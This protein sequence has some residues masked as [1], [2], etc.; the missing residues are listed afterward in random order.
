MMTFA[1]QGRLKVLCCGCA[2]PKGFDRYEHFTM[3]PCRCWNK[4]F[5]QW[6]RSG[7]QRRGWLCGAR[8]SAPPQCAGPA[9][10]SSQEDV[11]R[12]ATCMIQAKRVAVGVLSLILLD[13]QASFLI[14]LTMS[15]EL[16]CICCTGKGP[17]VGRFYLPDLGGAAATALLQGLLAEPCTCMPSDISCSGQG[18][19]LQLRDMKGARESHFHSGSHLMLRWCISCAEHPASNVAC[20]VLV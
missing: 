3:P 16:S 4:G 6:R 20:L 8:Q 5:L 14:D 1:S 9:G 18:R 7:S 11:P 19:T 15:Q 12:A 10:T 17:Y 13:L 2:C